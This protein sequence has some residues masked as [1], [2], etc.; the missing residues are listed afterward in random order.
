MESS[1]FI[2]AL[3]LILTTLGGIIALVALVVFLIKKN[4]EVK[5][6]S[7]EEVEKE[8]DSTKEAVKLS[9]EA[10]LN[11]LAEDVL[12]HLDRIVDK[13]VELEELFLQR[14][15][16][17]MVKFDIRRVVTVHLK[18]VV[19]KYARISGEKSVSINGVLEKIEAELDEVIKMVNDGNLR[20]YQKKE[21]FVD[22]RLSDSF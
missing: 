14:E 11:G 1:L 21:R 19:E 9:F 3:P 5:E 13:T 6:S 7:S 8:V 20:D 10:R 15:V 22:I 16:A 17:P 12:T 18:D 4:A 2:S